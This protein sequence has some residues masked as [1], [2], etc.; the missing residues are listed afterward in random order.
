M[1]ASYNHIPWIVDSAYFGKLFK[2]KAKAWAQLTVQLLWE[3]GGPV[4]VARTAVALGVYV[5]RAQGFRI[6]S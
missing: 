3:H 5:D 1:D 6:E 4:R 2:A